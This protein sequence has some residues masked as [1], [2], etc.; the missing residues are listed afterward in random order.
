MQYADANLYIVRHNYSK[1]KSLSVV[2]NIFKNKNI[3]NLNIVINDYTHKMKDTGTGMGTGMEM[4]DTDIMK[5]MMN[6]INMLFV[7]VTKT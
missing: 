1:I 4:M 3:S 5:Q 6:N 2:N 7:C